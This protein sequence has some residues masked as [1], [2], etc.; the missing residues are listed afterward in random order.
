MKKVVEDAQAEGLEKFL[1]EKITLFCLNYIYTGR[2]L[3]VNDSC[4]LL[5][6]AAVVYETGAF[7]DKSWKDAQPLP[8]NWYVQRAAIESFGSLK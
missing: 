5:A 7:N 8:Q 1:G 2:L 4:V 6:E 3:G